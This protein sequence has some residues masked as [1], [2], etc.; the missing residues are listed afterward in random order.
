[1][2]LNTVASQI[3]DLIYDDT[4]SPPPWRSP[5]RRCFHHVTH[6]LQERWIQLG[7]HRDVARTR[8]TS[9][10]LRSLAGFASISGTRGRVTF[11]TASGSFA[12][13]GL[14]FEAP[15]LR[16]SQLITANCSVPAREHCIQDSRLSRPS[17]PIVRIARD[18][19]RFPRPSFCT[20][21]NG[22]NAS[23]CDTHPI[24]SR[25]PALD[26]VRRRLPRCNLCPS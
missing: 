6:R 26:P 24:C 22:L 4:A 13:L 7:T 12:L 8:K 3:A 19:I 20:T 9:V 1:V 5:I 11:A 16:R 14:R 17:T 10:V 21:T 25:W 23:A 18:P 2:P 15:P